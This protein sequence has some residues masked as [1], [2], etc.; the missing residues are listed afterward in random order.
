[1][2]IDKAAGKRMELK[3]KK[4]EEGGRGVPENPW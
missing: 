3:K 1:M 2:K 4:R